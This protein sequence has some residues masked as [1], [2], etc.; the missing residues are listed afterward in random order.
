VR[1]LFDLPAPLLDWIDELLTAFL[2]VPAAILF[3][4]VI[5]AVLCL[6]LYRIC[7]PQA[8]IATIRQEAGA[9]QERLSSFEGEFG[10]AWPLIRNLLGLSL[11]RVALV[12]PATLIGAYPVVALLIWLSNSYGYALPEPGEDVV[13]AVSAPLAARW[14]DGNGA[15]PARIQALQPDGEIA[16]EV[17]LVAASP[18]IHKRAW[19]NWLVANPAGYLPDDAPVDEIRTGLSR[20]EMVA[21]GPS[22]VRGWEA[23]FLP[24]LILAALVYK[25]VRR[26]H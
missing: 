15:E 8:R 20:R 10:D 22:W 12:L 21:A 9:A 6:E 11:R 26:I 7:S 17:N 18:V 13:P 19:W 5:G 3:W 23:V 25:H 2:P 4:S 14:L 24:G 1:G 16:L